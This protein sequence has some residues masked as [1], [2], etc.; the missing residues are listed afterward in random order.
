MAGKK[1]PR[2]TDWWLNHP[3]RED[4]PPRWRSFSPVV[5]DV[6]QNKGGRPPSLTNALIKRAQAT[7]R[8]ELRKNQHT[9]RTK[10]AAVKWLRDKNKSGLTI[11]ADIHDKTVQRAIIDGLWDARDPRR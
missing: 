10:K 3:F 7:L 1:S 8:A 6:E 5:D 4:L 2:P 9:F 11:H